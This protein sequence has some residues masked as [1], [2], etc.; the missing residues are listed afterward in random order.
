MG[1]KKNARREHDARDGL[2]HALALRAGRD[3]DVIVPAES[4]GGGGSVLIGV[5][6]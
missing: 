1:W 4:S 3:D 2:D 5:V 6:V